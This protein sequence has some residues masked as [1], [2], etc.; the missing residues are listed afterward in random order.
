MAAPN[1][2]RTDRIG[3]VVDPGDNLNMGNPSS[4]VGEWNVVGCVVAAV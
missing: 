2:D 3:N 1:T 4:V